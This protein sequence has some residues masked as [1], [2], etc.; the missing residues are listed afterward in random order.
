MRVQVMLRLMIGRRNL[1][2]LLWP[3][4]W[5]LLRSA[6]EMLPEISG[7]VLKKQ[8]EQINFVQRLVNGREVSFYRRHRFRFLAFEETLLFRNRGDLLL[9][10]ASLRCEQGDELAAKLWVTNGRLFQIT[11]GAPPCRRFFRT[12]RVVSCEL[13]F[14]PQQQSRSSTEVR[15]VDVD[16]VLSLLGV[17]TSVSTLQ[18]PTS[19]DRLREFSASLKTQFP[20]DYLKLMMLTD[21]CT[22]DGW[23]ILPSADIYHVVDVDREY[24]VIAQCEGLGVLAVEAGAKEAKMYFIDYIDDSKQLLPSL[25]TDSLRTIRGAGRSRG[26]VS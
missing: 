14:D 19:G 3:A 7:A 25:L 10:S 9:A 26:S 22:T 11:Y 1:R 23:R 20:V 2:E 12:A 16:A 8:L 24:V 13:N 15:A 21:G 6:S 4:E 17:S 18:A 5:E